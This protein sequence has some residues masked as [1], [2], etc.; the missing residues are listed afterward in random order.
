MRPE[1]W[2]PHAWL[3]FH[4]IA[5]SY[6]SPPGKHDR[7]TYRQFFHLFGQVLPCTKCR[8]HYARHIANIPVEPH[9]ESRKNLFDW[10]VAMH[11]AVNACGGKPQYAP[12]A[13]FELLRKRFEEGVKKALPETCQR[14]G[15]NNVWTSAALVVLLLLLCVAVAVVIVTGA[16]AVTRT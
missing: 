5:L 6:P 7:D 8:D 15:N 12:E 9:L 3:T 4:A 13:A 14:P 10:S 11:N 2:G 1:L 16:T